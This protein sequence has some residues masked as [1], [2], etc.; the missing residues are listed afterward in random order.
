M[1]SRQEPWGRSSCIFLYPCTSSVSFRRVVVKSNSHSFGCW[2]AWF[3]LAKPRFYLCL[4]CRFGDH[5]ECRKG[6]CGCECGSSAEAASLSTRD[7]AVKRSKVAAA[8][9]ASGTRYAA[10]SHSDPTVRRRR[11]LYT[12]AQLKLALEGRSAGQ[13][14]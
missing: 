13:V 7:M 3:E 9:S 4:S 6:K 11:P 5:A 1:T 12:A 8:S 14:S 10:L 2:K